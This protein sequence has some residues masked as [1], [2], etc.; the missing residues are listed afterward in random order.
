MIYK[1]IKSDNDSHTDIHLCIKFFTF[2]KDLIKIIPKEAL[3]LQVLNLT[4]VQGC[5]IFFLIVY[6]LVFS[7][8][9]KW[10]VQHDTL[11]EIIDRNINIIVIYFRRYKFGQQSVPCYLTSNV[12]MSTP[13]ILIDSLV[14]IFINSGAIIIEEKDIKIP[15]LHVDSGLVSCSLNATNKMF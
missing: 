15:A 3:P 6:H 4:V 7:K 14:A 11:C 8:K 2:L 12:Q 9:K 13:L 5:N 1:L 10:P